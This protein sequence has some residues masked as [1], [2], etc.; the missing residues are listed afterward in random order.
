MHAI[1][2]LAA[3]SLTAIPP[4]GTIKLTPGFGDTLRQP[5]IQ[6]IAV[7]S[8]DVVDVQSTGAGELLFT[9]KHRGRTNVT[10]W[11]KNGKTVTRQV[12]VEDEKQGELEKTIHDMV[13]PVLEVKRVGDRTIV[14]GKLDSMEEFY[15]LKKIVGDDPNVVILAKMNPAVLPFLAEQITQ[16]LRRNGIKE[17]SAV[18]VGGRILLEG[19]VAD[20]AEK[21]KAEMIA[22]AYY[23]GWQGG[24]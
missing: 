24:E 22:T 15:R 21:S 2:L 5:G 1:L 9:G 14:D 11:F 20:E 8:P 3:V 7:S 10:I 17:A 6:K 13:N 18:A 16:A 23:A 4:E 19:S 12:V